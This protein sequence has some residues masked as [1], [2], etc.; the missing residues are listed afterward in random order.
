MP[1]D[2][3]IAAGPDLKGDPM[4]LLEARDGTR[5]LLELLAELPPSQREVLRLRFQESL[6]YKEIS[7]VTQHSVS[8]V[9]VLIHTGLKTLRLKLGLTVSPRAMEGGRS[10][11]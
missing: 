11:A 8:H 5:H 7:V 1:L 3:G 4:R 10:H 9:G 2:E 6:S